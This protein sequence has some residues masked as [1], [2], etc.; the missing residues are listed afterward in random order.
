MSKLNL[1]NFEGDKKLFTQYKNTLKL[2]KL[3]G[4]FTTHSF[5]S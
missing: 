1:T 3:V 4:R 5:T 2:L